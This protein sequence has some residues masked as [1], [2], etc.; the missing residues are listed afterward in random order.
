MKQKLHEIKERVKDKK[1]APAFN[2]IHTFLYTPNEVTHKG[3][4]HV[5]AADDLKANHEYGYY[6]IGSVFTFRNL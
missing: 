1:W 5:K 4:T 2:A 3:G 6:V